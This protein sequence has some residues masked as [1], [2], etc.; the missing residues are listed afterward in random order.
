MALICILLGLILERVLAE[1]RD[2]HSFRWFDAYSNWLMRHLPGM[3]SQGASSIII[4][5]VPLL[6]PVLL[7]QN[8]LDDKFNDLFSFLFGLAIFIYCLGA[9]EL[10]SDI[11]HYL[12]AREAGNEDLAAR[13]ASAITGK[14]ASPALDQQI[15]EVMHG[16]LSQSVPRIFAVIFWF[17]LL[18]PLGALLY[19][20]TARAMINRDQTLHLAARKFE[21]MLAWAP[22]HIVAFGYAL[23]GD[24]EGATHAYRVRQRQSDLA[25]CNYQVL[26]NAG[27]GALRECR[28]GEETACI[29][30]TRGLVLRTLVL[31][32]AIVA[33]LTLAGWMS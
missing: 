30:S 17:L 26:I 33:I 32:L 25:N 10:D 23:A 31:W 24:F 22:T 4:L 29:R 19:R 9:N 21:A 1:Q 11:D 18:G 3:N 2:L 7:L 27:L 5:L 28:P 20:L 15:A 12:D 16:I 14:P 13:H 6:L 8:A